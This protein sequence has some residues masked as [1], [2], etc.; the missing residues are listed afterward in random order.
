MIKPIY[1]YAWVYFKYDR[2]GYKIMLH[3]SNSIILNDFINKAS[4]DKLDLIIEQAM[5]FGKFGEAKVRMVA[6]K[7]N[8][9]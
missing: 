9:K 1:C 2:F 6:K 3:N 7:V 5:Y 8:R 4:C